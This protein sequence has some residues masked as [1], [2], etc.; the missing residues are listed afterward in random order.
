MMIAMHQEIHADR[1]YLKGNCKI[2]YF[3]RT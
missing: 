3:N 1:D 2:I